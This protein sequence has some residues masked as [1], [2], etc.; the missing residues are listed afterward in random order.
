MVC[1]FVLGDNL[2]AAVLGTQ[3]WIFGDGKG[4]LALWMTRFDM[5]QRPQLA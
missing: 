4:G 2:A 5:L 3:D 1:Q